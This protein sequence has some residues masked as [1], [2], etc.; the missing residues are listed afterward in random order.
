[1]KTQLINVRSLYPDFTPYVT[2]Y[3]DNGLSKSEKELKNYFEYYKFKS[4]NF[5]L[6]YLKIKSEDI[7]RPTLESYKKMYFAARWFKRK[8]N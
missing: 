7:I 1:M 2:K 8:L 4:L 3:G 5:W 6:D